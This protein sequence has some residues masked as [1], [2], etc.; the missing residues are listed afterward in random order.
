MDIAKEIDDTSKTIR[1]R[2]EQ[3]E[4]EGSIEYMLTWNAAYSTEA[5]FIIRVDLKPGMDMNKHVSTLNRRHGA[6]LILT[7]VHSSILDY[8][9]EYCRAPTIAQ[10]QELIETLKRDEEV[11][12]VTSGI[13]HKE[14]NCETRRD[15]LLR[16]RAA[17][18][19]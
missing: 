13:V 14:W 7:L 18:F 11:A 12:K 4:R 6:R 15:L 8:D 5:N 3:M 16:D 9:C 1:N 17:N 19:L 2:L 10:H